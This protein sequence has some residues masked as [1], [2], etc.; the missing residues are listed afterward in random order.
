MKTKF[1]YHA[2]AVGASGYLTLPFQEQIE[3]QASAA[4]PTNGGHGTARSENFNHRNVLS[5]HSALS[6]VTGSY[7]ARDK[8]HGTVTSVVVEGVSVLGVVT[9][10]RIVLRLTSKHDDG[11]GEPSFMIHGSHFD[12]LKIAGHPINAELATD[13]FS[14]YST[15]SKLSQA[16]AH[17]E[18][19]R[20][21][22][23]GLT[24]LQREDNSLP[25]SKG[26]V[27]VTL[28]RNLDKLPGGLT[29]NGHGIY[30]PHFGT[31]YLGEFFISRESRRLMMLHVDL[32]CA[33]EGCGGVGSGQGG[34]LPW[35]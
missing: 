4:L 27:G 25:E 30:V 12:N 28:A 19:F 26:I 16:H 9:C 20:G 24:L 18:K 34:G 32:G 10:D 11:G 35:P 15:W 13:L 7:S 29:R 33:F 3:I 14:E 5:F 17:N 2:E 1:L 21:E 31:V 23:K 8:A 6:T 22:M